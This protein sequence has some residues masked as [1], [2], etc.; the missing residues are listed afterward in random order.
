[1]LF[2]N[3]DEVFYMPVVEKVCDDWQSGWSGIL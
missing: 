2:K 3:I 1:M